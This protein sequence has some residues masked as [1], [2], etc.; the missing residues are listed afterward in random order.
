VGKDG[1]SPFIWIL[2]GALYGIILRVGFGVI[3]AILPLD[4]VMSAAF[5]LGTPVVIGAIAVYGKRHQHRSLWFLIFGPWVAVF[6]MLL[7]SAL[8]LLEGAI[9]IA[10]M[11]PLFL[12]CG[13]AGGI[14]M[15]LILCFREPSSGQV[16]SLAVLPFLILVAEAFAPMMNSHV[17]I[18]DSVMINASPEIVWAQ[19]LTAEDI[20]ADELPF[21]ISHTIGVPRPIEGINRMT[22]AGEIRFSRWER[23]VRFEGRVTERR[24]HES[25]RWHYSFDAHSFPEG[26]MDEHVEIGGRYFSLEDTTFNLRPVPGRGTELEL[27]AHY[28]VS[29]GINFYALP[30]ARFLGHDFVNTILGLYKGRSENAALQPT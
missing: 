6:F 17:E 30:V 3:P 10:L 24:E 22:P 2:V 23:G 21:S 15:G 4:G 14:I 28:R 11:A 16:L 9:C 20:E 29:T 19:I 26:S 7:G 27:I 25:I 8:A 5:L 12:I 13:S 1:S 18:R